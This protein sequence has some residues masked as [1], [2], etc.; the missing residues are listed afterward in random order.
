MVDVKHVPGRIKSDADKPAVRLWLKAKRADVT[1][2]KG[3][4]GDP[5]PFGPEGAR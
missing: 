5:S 1:L 2:V 3:K 4:F